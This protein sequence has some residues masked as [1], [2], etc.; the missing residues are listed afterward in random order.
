MGLYR[1]G[2]TYWFSIQYKGKRIQESLTTDNKRL[3]DKLHAKVLTDIIEGRYFEREEAKKH[4]FEDMMNRF[5]QEYAVKREPSTQERYISCHKNLSRYFHDMT[6]AGITP[7]T[8]SA[9]V[10][11]RRSEGS[12]A[13][14][15]NREIAMLSKAFNLAMKQWEWCNSNPCSRISKEPE[16]NTID[17][18]LTSDEE[19]RLLEG[20]RGYINGQLTEIIIFALNTGMRQGEILNLK[21]QDIDFS[22]R[23]VS[24]KKTKNKDPKVIPLNQ[25][26]LTML[27]KKRKVV[28]ITG[29]VFATQQGSMINRWNLKR[30]FKNALRKAQVSSFRFHDLRHTFAT[31]LVQSGAE[32]YSV[33]KLLGHRDISTTQRYA[34]HYPESLRSSVEILDKCYKSATI[35]MS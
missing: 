17:R 20:S 13:A 32:L 8:I 22:R 24:V 34:H 35:G 12:A 23:I 33:A 19:Q 28:T 3:A 15:V 31:R 11:L 29:Y 30:E 26:V 5:M 6:L 25:S 2:K 7:K 10:H 1:R 21:W 9:Y 18:W 4:T 14:T 27:L 16:N